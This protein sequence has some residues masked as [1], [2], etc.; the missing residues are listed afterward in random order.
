MNWAGGRKRLEKS[1]PPLKRVGLN[2]LKE[3]GRG[4]GFESRAE[5][6]GNDAHVVPG[7]LVAVEFIDEN[8]SGPGVWLR[9]RY[10]K[11]S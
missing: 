11:K 4:C 3:M 9:R 8:G 6:F 2:L 7:Q 1:A 5:K 10:Q